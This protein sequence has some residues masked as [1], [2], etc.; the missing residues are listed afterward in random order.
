MVSDASKMQQAWRNIIRPDRLYILY[1]EVCAL[2]LLA[3]AALPGGF[4]Y[5]GYFDRMARGC[6]S[7]TYNPYFTEWF[8]RPLSLVQPRIG[9]LMTIAITMAVVWMVSRW[10]KGNPFVVLASGTLIWVFWLGQIDFIAA[11]GLGI[12]WWS[13]QNKKP[14]LAGLG[15]LMM[16]TKPQLMLFAI[17]AFIIWMGWQALIIPVLAALLSFALYGVDWPIRWLSYS[18]QTVF[19]G[20]A[21][22]YITSPIFLL[23][24]PAVF[25][26]K[27]RRDQLHYLLA[28]ACAGMPYVGAYSTFVL[29]LFPLR[30]WEILLG[31]LPFIV[32]FIGRSQWWLGLLM[33][34]MLAIMAR[35]LYENRTFSR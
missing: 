19:G 26:L 29:L 18:P 4:D 10:L 27:Q 12:A 20:D 5:W 9:Y 22:F 30:W 3:I 14:V 15:L 7:C 25:L 28:V 13:L 2:I 31:Y 8:L 21:W 24:L 32:M 6:V 1:I 11:L 16:A 35:L 17:P 23:A 34:Q 33:F